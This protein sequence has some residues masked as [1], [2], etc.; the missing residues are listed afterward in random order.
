MID[1]TDSAEISQQPNPA[2]EKF[3]I[4]RIAAIFLGIALLVSGTATIMAM[5]DYGPIKAEFTTAIWLLNL[6]L[7]LALGLVAVLAR[8]I[9]R[10]WIYRRHGSAGSKLH[11]RLVASFS[12]VAVVPALLVAAFSGIFLNLGIETWFNDRVRTAVNESK[13]VA[14]AYLQEHQQNI[15]GAALGMANDI[16]RAARLSIRNPRIIA[17]IMRSQSAVRELSEAL[18]VDSKG[19]TLLR[20]GFGFSLEF[21]FASDGIVKGLLNK[22][23]GEVVII[24]G[25]ADDRVIAG[26]KLEAFADAYLLVGRFVKPQ[27]LDHLSR[28]R[29]ATAQYQKLE[30]SRESLQLKFLL[31][32][33]LVAI[34]L[35]LAAIWIG[36]SLASQLSTPIGNLI[37]AAE[38]VRKG[39][40]NVKVLTD[41]ATT[42]DEIGTLGRTFNS[43]TD[44]LET[45]QNGLMEANRQLDERR[46]FT[47]TVLAGVSAGV[48]G[49]DSDGRIHLPNRS[50][51]EL[52]D[53]ELEF[54]IAEPLEKIVPEMA[55]LFGTARKTPNRTAQGEIQLSDGSRRKTLLVSIA[56]EQIAGEVIGY[57]V[58]FDDV[59]EL[60]SAQRKAAWADVARRIAHEIKNPLTPIQLSA[61]RLRRKYKDEITSDPDTF[62]ICTDTIIRQVEDIGRMVDEFS[63]FARTPRP[64]LRSANLVEICRQSVFLERNRFAKITYD[65]DLPDEPVIVGCDRQQIGRVLTNIMKN[66]AEAIEAKSNGEAEPGEGGRIQM[67]MTN[68]DDETVIKITDNG[69]GFPEDLM[70]RITEPY[71]TTREKGTGLGLAIA[72]KIM[73]DHG[74]DLTVENNNGSGATVTLLFH[75]AD[76]QAPLP[77]D[78]HPDPENQKAAAR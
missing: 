18:V 22:R 63:S 58:T 9:V 6:D 76:V 46:R 66:A 61:E 39:D 78:T 15:G 26:V 33:G 41:T 64:E 48:I 31:V 37:D 51:S 77:E 2:G 50:A 3:S 19:N 56:A 21:N 47:E 24:R 32:F 68:K 25:G 59:T 49:L 30:Q 10:A 70:D 45:Q 38:R 71:V 67:Q 75:K 40:L 28:T 54:H 17:D 55:D 36:W 1:T 8:R 16:N 73:E 5:A 12:L 11:I 43:M 44:Q 53:I 74:G 20:S 52:L 14:E 35:L 4:T 60:F 65:L 69:R 13:L 34:L 27:V 42:D 23:P 62:L 57:V 7:V 72:M 29:G